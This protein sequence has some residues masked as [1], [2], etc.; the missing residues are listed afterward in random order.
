MIA[1]RCRCPGSHHD[2]FQFVDI[3]G[4]VKAMYVDPTFG[5]FKEPDDN[6]TAVPHN[7]GIRKRNSQHRLRFTAD[8]MNIAE[9]DFLEQGIIL[10]DEIRRCFLKTTAKWEV[11]Q[12]IS[13]STL[14]K[15]LARET[16]SWTAVCFSTWKQTNAIVLP[17]AFLKSASFPE[18]LHQPNANKRRP[19]EFTCWAEHRYK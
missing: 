19:H 7:Q 18:R 5:N 4:N 6:D 3:W 13:K 16:S 12:N 15:C 8:L 9:F 1:A 14:N 2:L 17:Y 10:S 11:L